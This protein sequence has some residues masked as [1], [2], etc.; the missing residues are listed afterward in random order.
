[1]TTI[2]DLGMEAFSAW[3]FPVGGIVFALVGFLFLLIPALFLN[4]Y[5]KRIGQGQS[6]IL[7]GLAGMIFSAATF[8]YITWPYLSEM[9]LLKSHAYQAVEGP[10]TNY[11]PGTIHPVTDEEFTVG[12]VHFKVEPYAPASFGGFAQTK[13]THPEGTYVRIMYDGKRSQFIL[14]IEGKL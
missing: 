13:L 4:R 5:A 10:L 2:F 7:I 1:L 3:C 8:A 12:G 11:K 14:R 9:E 6:S